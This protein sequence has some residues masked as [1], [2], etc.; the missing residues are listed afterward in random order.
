MRK[1]RSLIAVAMVMVMA[2]TMSSVS[3]FASETNTNSEVAS[4]GFST[5]DTPSTRGNNY[6]YPSSSSSLYVSSTSWATIATSTSG[7]N[8]NVRI[9]GLVIGNY[10]IDV[11]MLDSSGNVVWSESNAINTASTGY[12]VF[13]CG[14]N[15]RT[16]Q[17]KGHSG[18]GIAWA[19]QV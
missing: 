5:P 16:I 14:S 1:L 7:F 15:V 6:P 12:R 2:L 9:E 3:A 13:W 10:C 19:Y 8:C 18:N 4:V 17:V 11:R